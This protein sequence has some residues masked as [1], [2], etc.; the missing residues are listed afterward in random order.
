[1]IMPQ[2]DNQK[3]PTFFHLC[4]RLLKSTTAT[5]RHGGSQHAHTTT[6][7]FTS[8]FCLASDD[9]QFLRSSIS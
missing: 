5:C 6:T 1:M 8:L 9:H 2:I 3:N 7:T 4:M